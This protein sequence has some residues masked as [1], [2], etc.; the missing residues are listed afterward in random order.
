[1]SAGSDILVRRLNATEVRA[2]LDGLAAV[3]V[4]CV[5]GGASVSYLAP[6]SHERR[7]TNSRR[8]RQMSKTA[9]GCFSLPSRGT[10]SSAPSRSSPRRHRT[11]PIAR[12]SRKCWCAAARGAVASAL[13]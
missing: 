9:A 13:R 2:Q 3:L 8:G 11:S 10:R 1:M 6:F 12:M 5:A 7:A 4:D